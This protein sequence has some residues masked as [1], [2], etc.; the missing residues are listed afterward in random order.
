MENGGERARK[1]SIGTVRITARFGGEG[2][3]IRTGA[4]DN[5]AVGTEGGG[6]NLTGKPRGGGGRITTPLCISFI[7][8]SYSNS[9]EPRNF[10]I[11]TYDIGK[12]KLI[13]I[14]KSN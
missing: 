5:D 9:N 4:L 11:N 8:Q 2:A 3:G 14:T 12:K 7:A 1:V 6:G 13:K 10:A